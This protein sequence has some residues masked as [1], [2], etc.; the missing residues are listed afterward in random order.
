MNS[1]DAAITGLPKNC[2]KLSTEFQERDHF[3][4][5]QLEAIGAKREH[6]SIVDLKGKRKFLVTTKYPRTESYL[7]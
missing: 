3:S 5:K 6:G 7:V 2:K 4:A 1:L